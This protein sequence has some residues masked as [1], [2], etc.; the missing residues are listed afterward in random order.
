MYECA[1]LWIFIA[2]VLICD[3]SF[4]RLHLSNIV[5]DLPVIG[6]FIEEA[7]YLQ[8]RKSDLQLLCVD[9]SSVALILIENNFNVKILPILSVLL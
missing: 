3:M 5:R 8:K 7:G 1:Y 6:T 4:K 9:L 2:V